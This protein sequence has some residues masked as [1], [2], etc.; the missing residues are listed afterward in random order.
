MTNELRPAYFFSGLEL[1]HESPA[2]CSCAPSYLFY[3]A[4]ST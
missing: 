1:D 2:L 4:R 3:D